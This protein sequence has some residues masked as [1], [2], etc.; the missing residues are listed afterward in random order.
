MSA[1]LF[2]LQSLSLPLGSKTLF[3]NFVTDFANPA[4]ETLIYSELVELELTNLWQACFLNRGTV[5]FLG[6]SEVSLELTMGV[7]LQVPHCVPVMVQGVLLLPSFY[8]SA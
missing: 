8:K 3:L 5:I 7:M 6:N 1:I 2:F 4:L